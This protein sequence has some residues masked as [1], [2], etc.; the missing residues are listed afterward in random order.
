[1]S[2]KEGDAV[3]IELQG[4]GRYVL[5]PRVAVGHSIKAWK[6]ARFDAGLLV[7]AQWGALFE[8]RDGKLHPLEEPPSA[9][10]YAALATKSG[11]DNRALSQAGGAQAL[12]QAE[13]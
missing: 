5:V 6:K 10:Q 12:G 8:V 4:A 9:A 1:M 2:V 3:A 7:G 13:V 11:A